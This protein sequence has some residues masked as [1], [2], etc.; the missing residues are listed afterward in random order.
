MSSVQK[1]C[2]VCG[3][4]VAA[5]KRVKDQKGQYYCEP[6]FAQR[7]AAQ[8]KGAPGAVRAP[9]GAAVAVDLAPPAENGELDLA[10]ERKATPQETPML[11]CSKCKKLKP[12]KQVRNVDGEFIC[13]NCF[14]QHNKPQPPSA[15]MKAAVARAKVSDEES[16]A[17]AEGFAHSLVGSLVISAGI[18]AG[19][20]VLMFALYYF[21]PD[22]KDSSIL[23]AGVSAVV[24]TVF[25]VVRALALIG[26]MVVA[27]HILGGISFGY[28]GPAFYKS[29]GFFTFFTVLSFFIS[30]SESL[31]MLGFGFRWGLLVLGFIAVFGIDYF[32]AVILAVVNFF[33]GLGL[34]IA[35]IATTALLL[36]IVSGGPHLDTDFDE[37]P[38]AR[39]VVP[40]GPPAAL[41]GGPAAPQP[42]NVPADAPPPALENPG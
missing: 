6:C 7:R 21:F 5:R 16:E 25:L 30:K 41:P 33:L 11:G 38:P 20:L 4:D 1:L 22:A 10:P 37:G 17:Q 39:Q 27:A 23:V 26:S 9:A 18:V 13:I 28:L 32:E 36:G 2:S 34:T 35:M 8:P 12:E 29:L 42:D 3:E 31:F 24:Q 14:A 15:K 19:Y 40:G